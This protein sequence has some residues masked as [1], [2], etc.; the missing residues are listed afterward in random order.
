VRLP[1]GDLLPSTDSATAVAALF[2]CVDSTTKSSD[3]PSAFM[4][5]VPSE[6]FAGRS[7]S[8]PQSV[9]HLRLMGSPGS[10]VWNFHACTG[11]KTPPCPRRSRQIAIAAMWPSPCQDKV[12]TRKGCRVQLTKT[13]ELNSWPTIPPSRTLSTVS[14][15]SPHLRRRP[16]QVANS[17]S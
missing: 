2:I 10:R 11:S 4:P 15:P 1:F 8:E 13:G 17:S 14:L 16:K 12:G 7:G 5:A 9:L 6:R 3:F